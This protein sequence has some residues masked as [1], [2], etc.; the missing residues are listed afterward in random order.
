MSFEVVVIGQINTMEKALQQSC[1]DRGTGTTGRCYKGK[2][3]GCSPVSEESRFA[4][5]SSTKEGSLET[6]PSLVAVSP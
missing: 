5:E 1:G 3:E 4:G 2:E 6:D